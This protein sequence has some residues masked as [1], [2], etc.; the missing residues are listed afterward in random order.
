[1]QVVLRHV[2]L[3]PIKPQLKLIT[4]SGWSRYAVAR[5]AGLYCLQ[6]HLH[7]AYSPNKPG[8]GRLLPVT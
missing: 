8:T 2:E 5:M 3:N 4:V 1:M 6:L 7:Q